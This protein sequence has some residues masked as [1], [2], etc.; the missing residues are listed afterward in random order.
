MMDNYDCFDLAQPMSILSSGTQDLYRRW[1][2]RFIAY[3]HQVDVAS[4]NIHALSLQQTAAVLSYNM[5]VEWFGAVKMENPQRGRDSFQSARN[6]VNW[7]ARL[8]ADM[9]LIDSLLTMRLRELPLPRAEIGQNPG[10]WLSQTE[11]NVLVET[12]L[13]T[14]HWPLHMRRRNLAL[15]GLML[16]AGLRRGEVQAIVWGD[17]FDDHRQIFLRVHGKG[18]KFRIVKLPTLL[19]EWIEAWRQASPQTKPLNAMFID[20]NHHPQD[21]QY[22]PLGGFGIYQVVKIVCAVAGLPAAS[23]HDLRRSFSRLAQENGA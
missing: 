4:V 5:V 18:A 2:I 11:S 9:D 16:L 13:T 17:L 1:I 6:A 7:L 12:V 15:I 3:L 8:L 14:S 20:L 19:A 22:R 10:T 23:P 21:G